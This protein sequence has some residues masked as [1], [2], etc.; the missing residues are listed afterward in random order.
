MPGFRKKRDRFFVS[1]STTR[2]TP[3]LAL[4][5]LQNKKFFEDRGE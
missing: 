4:S 1:N 5:S 2:S 3:A